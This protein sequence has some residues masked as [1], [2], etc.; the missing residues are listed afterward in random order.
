MLVVLLV[1][2]LNCLIFIFFEKEGKGKRKGGLSAN[3]FEARWTVDGEYAAAR[4]KDSGKKESF[5]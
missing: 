3:A 5:L 1:V 2:S 4:T